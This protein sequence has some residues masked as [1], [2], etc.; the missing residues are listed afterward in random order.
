M[1]L[2]LA[3]QTRA[4]REKLVGGAGDYDNAA[5]ELCL[6]GS[7][8]GNSLRLY[9]GAHSKPLLACDFRAG[10]NA[11]SIVMPHLLFEFLGINHVG[12]ASS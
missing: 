2:I 8:K 3:L 10:L 11:K 7:R 1:F 4:S 12:L 5:A 9:A 6:G